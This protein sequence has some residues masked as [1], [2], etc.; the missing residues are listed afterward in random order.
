MRKYITPLFQEKGEGCEGFFGKTFLYVRVR[1]LA[2]VRFTTSAALLLLTF[3]QHT[4][5]V[6]MP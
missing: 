5:A 4:N 2:L 1:I 3:F 6:R